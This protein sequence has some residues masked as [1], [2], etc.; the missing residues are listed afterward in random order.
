VL[1]LER[2]NWRAYVQTR[3]QAPDPIA[4][5]PPGTPPVA[6]AP[7]GSPAW[8][9]GTLGIVPNNLRSGPY[10]LHPLLKSVQGL[11]STERR[12]AVL[13]NV[14]QLVMP[15]TKAQFAL[16]SHPKPARMF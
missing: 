4:L 15:T 3:N 13:A 10:A 14:G 2:N 5:L 11:F 8:L 6:S 9:G 7:V 12:L 1:P 16:A